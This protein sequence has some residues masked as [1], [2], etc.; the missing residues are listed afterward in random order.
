MYAMLTFYRDDSGISA[1]LRKKIQELEASRNNFAKY[2]SDEQKKAIAQS[3]DTTE[4]ILALVDSA[5]FT[6]CE[7]SRSGNEVANTLKRKFHQVCKSLDQ[8]DGLFSLLPKESEY[9][10][11]F[12]GAINSVIAVSSILTCIWVGNT[13]ILALGICHAPSNG[14]WAPEDR[15]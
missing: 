14:H 1:T 13:D 9:V 12:Y 7:R 3:P 6:W 8:H 10:S 11:I 5:N 4:A 2:L 15:G